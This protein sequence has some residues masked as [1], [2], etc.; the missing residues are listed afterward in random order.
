GLLQTKLVGHRVL[1]NGALEEIWIVARVQSRGVRERE[2]A[3]ILLR[4]VAFL[5]HLERFGNHFLEIAH[6]EMREVGAEY[7]PQPDAHARIEGEYGRM[8]VG[9]ATEV[10]IF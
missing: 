4:H 1:D 9:L 7:R 3:E 8:I 2:L 6:V 10:E 5:D